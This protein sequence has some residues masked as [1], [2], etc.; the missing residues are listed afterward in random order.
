MKILY[1]KAIKTGQLSRD[2]VFDK[3]PGFTVDVLFDE[4]DIFNYWI[5][6]F[7]NLHVVQKGNPYEPY[8]YSV[9]NDMWITKEVFNSYF[10]KIPD[11]GFP[12]NFPPKGGCNGT[13]G[14]SGTNIFAGTTETPPVNTGIVDH[15]NY[16]KQQMLTFAETCMIDLLSTKSEYSEYPELSSLD[17]HKIKQVLLKWK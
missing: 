1:C 6:E 4:G 12:R 11:P 10:K 14:T 8:P 3:S 17:L 13:S 15:S 16:S 7:N 2:W 5:S 9:P